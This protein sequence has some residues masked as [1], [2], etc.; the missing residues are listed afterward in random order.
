M[1][2]RLSGETRLYFTVGHP[3]A[4]VKSPTGVTRGFEARG[5]NAVVVPIDVPAD[6]IDGFFE[7][8]GRA[9]NVDGLVITVPYKFRAR[10]AC[11]TVSE[12]ARLLGVANVMRRNADGSWHGDM[13]DG[14]G[15]CN[16]VGAAG[17]EIA[18]KRALL[19]GAGGAGS[20]IGLSILDSGAA[21]LAVFDLDTA[22]RDA[23]IDKLRSRYPAVDAA[24][25]ADPTGFDLI[26]NASPAGMRPDDPLPVDVAGLTPAMHVGDVVTA[27]ELPPLIVAARAR[28]CSTNTGTEMYL[29]Q[30][31]VIA[32]F[33][34][35]RT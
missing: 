2:D 9:R 21:S 23:L 32:D 26:A 17:F 14:L 24:P 30:V 6:A 35:A 16:A 28:G 34:L 15:F 10:E 12:R 31:D 11:A 7:L 1:L 27:P 22:R 13:T 25:A 5:A 29:N 3:I 19:V 4:Q 18:G 33:L 20:A 8:A